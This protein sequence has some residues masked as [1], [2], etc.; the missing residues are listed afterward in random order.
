LSALDL[1]AL[2]DGVTT[3]ENDAVADMERDIPPGTQLIADEEYL[4][5]ALANLVRNAIRYAGT[6]GI[7]GGRSADDLQP[8]LSPDAER[9]R[10]SGGAGLGL[11]CEQQRRSVRG[12]RILP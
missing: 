10:R 2:V 11:N 1:T 8:V 6:A 9:T 4:T 12:K 3:Q 7:A 5:R